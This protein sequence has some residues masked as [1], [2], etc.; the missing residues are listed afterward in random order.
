MKIREE[1]EVVTRTIYVAE[2]GTCFNSK[3]ACEDYEF[4]EEHKKAGN[5]VYIV[6]D[7]RGGDR[8]EVFSTLELANNSIQNVEH[9]NYKVREKIIDM[10]YIR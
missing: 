1:Q 8:V 10:R 7:I 9:N 3:S 4:R 5:V 6:Y 2:D